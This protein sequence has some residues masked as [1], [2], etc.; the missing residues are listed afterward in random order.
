MHKTTKRFL[1]AYDKLPRQGQDFIR[2]LPKR[3][4]FTLDTVYASPCLKHLPGRRKM[5][6]LVRKRFEKENLAQS[7]AAS[8]NLNERV[9][10]EVEIFW[11]DAETSSWMTKTDKIFNYGRYDE[12][13]G[14]I[15]IQPVW[16]MREFD[17]WLRVQCRMCNQQEKKRHGARFTVIIPDWKESK[18]SDELIQYVDISTATIT[19]GSLLCA[20]KGNGRLRM[21]VW[22]EELYVW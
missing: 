21:R 18:T 4:R 15:Y 7:W 5:H 1:A 16:T 19:S 11:T 14:G 20:Y 6:P 2:S 13:D 10:K 17:S 3:Y 12:R 8:D 9:I 22:I